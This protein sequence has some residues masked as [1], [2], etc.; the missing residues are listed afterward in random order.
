MLRLK[1]IEELVA[2]ATAREPPEALA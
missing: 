2:L 1:H